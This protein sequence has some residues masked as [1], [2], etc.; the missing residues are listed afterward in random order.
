MFGHPTRLRASPLP[1]CPRG[2]GGR[3]RRSLRAWNSLEHRLPNPEPDA[4]GGVLQSVSFLCLFFLPSTKMQ[5]SKGKEYET[6]KASY[7]LN[8]GVIG[9]D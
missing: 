1:A 8:K 4:D 7:Y 5:K 9:T 3:G 6:K 2:A